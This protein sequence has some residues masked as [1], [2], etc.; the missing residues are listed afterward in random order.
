MRRFQ[1]AE[2]HKGRGG[3][4][5]GV[6]PGRYPPEVLDAHGLLALEIW[7]PPEPA[8]PAASHLQAFVCS[9]ARRGL[10]LALRKSAELDALLFPHICDTLQNLFTIVRD[11]IGHPIPCLTFYPPRNVSGESAA[12]YVEA[13][14]SALAREL[15]PLAAG[16]WDGEQ[17]VLARE[18]TGAL[19][20]ALR[21]AYL[22]RARAS[23]PRPNLDFYGLVRM[24]EY[25]PPG[26]FA[27]RLTSALETPAPG[28]DPA[29]RI[30]LSGVLPDRGLLEL[31]DERRLAVVEDDLLACGR[32]FLRAPAPDHDGDGWSGVARE[33]LRLPPCTTVASPVSRRLAFLLDLVER[34]SA[35]GV[36][37]HAVKFCEPELFDHPFVIDGLKKRGI[38]TLVLESELHE[39]RMGRLATRLDAFLEMLA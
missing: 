26:R 32:R 21:H 14:A 2:E 27:A 23:N 4:V 1:F 20:E 11:C 18:R 6:F 29:A 5:V 17:L 39:P 35:R 13:Q 3:R 38:S 22:S 16:P 19:H 34:S 28:P 12:G 15:A 36:V 31:L 9:V 37:L 25:L 30:V 10:D 8:G 24:R 33:F 7:D